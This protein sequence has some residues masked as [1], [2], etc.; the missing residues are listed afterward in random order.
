MKSQFIAWCGIWIGI[1]SDTIVENIMAL[2]TLEI[3]VDI[4]LILTFA[5]ISTYV[6]RAL[7]SSL[8]LLKARILGR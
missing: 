1:A 2:N 4:G 3:F 7:T 5:L 6:W 8:T